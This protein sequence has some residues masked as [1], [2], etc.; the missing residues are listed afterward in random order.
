MENLFEA[1]RV[2]YFLASN[3]GEFFYFPCPSYSRRYIRCFPC[4][5]PSKVLELLGCSEP[6]REYIFLCILRAINR[7]FVCFV[8]LLFP[9]LFFIAW[10]SLFEL[11]FEYRLIKL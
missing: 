10:L 1:L 8:T 3:E 9:F 4:M 2:S 7:S 5:L 6:C 11:D